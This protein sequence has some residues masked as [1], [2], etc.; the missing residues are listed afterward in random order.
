MGCGGNPSCTDCAES[1]AKLS[2]QSSIVTNPGPTFYDGL[3]REP[4]SSGPLQH[5]ILTGRVASEVMALTT[6]GRTSRMRQQIEMLA[7]ARKYQQLIG[8][9]LGFH[10]VEFRKGK[11]QDL[12]LDLELLD[13]YLS[14]NPVK[15]SSD[16][17]A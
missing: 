7:L 12:Q 4:D 6:S 9:R 8:E 16:S 5:T 13:Q 15:T 10:N 2:L 14:E 3:R 17:A 11:I 1:V